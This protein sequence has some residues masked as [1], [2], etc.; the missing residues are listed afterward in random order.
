MKS[1]RLRGCV[2]LTLF[3]LL[4]GSVA[5]QPTADQQAEMLL[6]AGRKAYADANPQF[7]ADR[8]REFLTKFG[9]HKDANA[10]RYGLGLAI[11]D[12]P[13][14][15]YQQ[16]LE[17]FTPAS[18]DAA[19]AD[20][21]LALYYAGVCR[22][23]LGQNEIAQGVQ[24]PNEMPQ[25]QQAANGHFTEAA[26]FFVSARESFEKKTP[27]DADWAARSRCDSAEMEIRLGKTK[28]ARTTAE[29][30][31]K[32]AGLAKSKFRPLGLYYH[33]FACFLMNDISAAGKSLNQLAPFDQP[34]G[35]HARY[36]M[37]RI[38]S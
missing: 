32:D 20:R 36:L 25:R 28:E 27:P 8:F 15:N 35:L 14:R 3:T 34:Y 9:G 38:F 16:A 33:G 18:N 5:A 17:A 26:K 11:L 7:A 30:F 12:L 29:P 23:G 31:V 24:R 37:G 19:F 13:D 4:L 1:I 21:P 6:N 22:R 10:A 2:A